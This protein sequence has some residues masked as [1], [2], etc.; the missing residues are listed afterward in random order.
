MHG[1]AAQRSIDTSFK[2]DSIGVTSEA[3]KQLNADNA[4]LYGVQLEQ[5]KT[6]RPKKD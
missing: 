4:L 6:G 3:F 5:L 2:N 1:S